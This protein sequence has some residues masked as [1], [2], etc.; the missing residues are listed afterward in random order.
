MKRAIALAIAL[1]ALSIGAHAAPAPFGNL[2]L[3]RTLA[4][5]DVTFIHDVNGPDMA[6]SAAV[7]PAATTCTPGTFGHC[8]TFTWTAPADATSSSTYNLYRELATCPATQPTTTAGF[9]KLT[10]GIAALTTTDSTAQA[11]IS[12]YFVT[13]TLNSLESVPSNTVQLSIQPDS[14]TITGSGQ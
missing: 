9:T 6:L 3:D 2:P 1:L 8:A 14:P 7:P 4:Q 5:I 13:Q 12:C 10:S 11:G